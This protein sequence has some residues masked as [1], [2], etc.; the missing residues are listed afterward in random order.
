MRASM[1]LQDN[2]TIEALRAAG[3][4]QAELRKASLFTND[5]KRAMIALN[6]ESSPQNR[7]NFAEAEAAHTQ[8]VGGLVASY[9]GSVPE[10][11]DTDDHFA[12]RIEAWQYL[13]DSG[14][15][16]GRS[17]FYEHC[18]EGRLPREKDGR[19]ARA[20]VDK[21]AALHCRLME[22]GEKVN[23]TSARMAEEKAETELEREKVRL[24]R[25]RHELA[26][27][28]GDYVPRDEV[29]LMIVGR[30][31]AMLAHLRAMVQ[32]RSSDW[33]ALV[34]GDQQRARDLIDTVHGDIEEHIAVFAKDIEFEIILEKN[35]NGSEG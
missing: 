21:Y 10:A 17:Q 28:R 31:V 25:E 19:Y 2:A 35:V 24:E 8:Y 14:W 22:T 9:L 4:T 11:Q 30:A 33:I 29:E 20:R 15:K 6:E 12:N 27:K 3:A 23:E 16:I 26:I 32:M 5:V 34:D 13:K 18:K 7:R 1:D